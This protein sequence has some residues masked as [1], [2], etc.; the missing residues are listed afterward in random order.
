MQMR[1]IAVSHPGPPDVME[2]AVGPMPTVGDTEVLIEVAA[3]GVNRP[4]VFQR[5]GK[6]PPPLGA[7]PILGLEVAGRVSEVGRDV[8]RW[9]VG[10]EVCALVAGG[11]YAEYCVAPAVQCLPIPRGLDLTTAAA[12]PETF[13]TVWTNLFDRGRLQPGEA[14]LVH[15]GSSGI[16]T[17]AIQLAHA[18]GARVFATAGSAEKCAACERLGAEQAINYRTGDFVAAV[19][20][21]TG[22]RGVDV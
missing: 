21:R 22:G 9:K 3:A 5:L 15:G 16:G 20:E 7:S 10:D 11:G 19:R 6:Y 12:I 2:L 13:F 18:N 17:T 14:V 4:D 8:T 1:Y